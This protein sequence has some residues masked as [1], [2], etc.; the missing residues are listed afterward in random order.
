MRCPRAVSYQLL[1]PLAAGLPLHAILEFGDPRD[2]SP[3][4][5]GEAAAAERCDQRGAGDVDRFAVVGEDLSSAIA[6][7]DR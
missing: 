5:T 6:A 1:T 4:R 7:A 2:G 3:R